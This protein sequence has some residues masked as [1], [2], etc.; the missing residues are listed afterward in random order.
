[1]TEILSLAADFIERMSNPAYGLAVNEEYS[2]RFA[3]LSDDDGVDGLLRHEAER[4]RDA[5]ALSAHGWI[6]FLNWARANDVALGGDLL[7]D[8]MDRWASVFMHVVIIDA[9]TR[10]AQWPERRRGVFHPAE[11]PDDWLRETMMRALRQERP[12]IGEKNRDL[13]LEPPRTERAENL[14][15]ALMQ[16][17]RPITQDAAAALVNHSWAGQPRLAEFLLSRLKPMD[18]ETRR[19]WAKQLQFTQS[20]EGRDR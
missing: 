20:D 16:V 3:H 10:Y 17:D 18:R 15:I 2:F 11:F 9:A 7:L 12:E 8:L 13:A 6:W 14:L 5:G 1:M 4:V 19:L